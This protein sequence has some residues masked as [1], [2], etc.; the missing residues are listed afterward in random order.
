MPAASAA[1]NACRAKFSQLNFSTISR[2]RFPISNLRSPIAATRAS[3]VANASQDFG[4]KMKPLER[5]SKEFSV[6]SWPL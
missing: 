2:D 5:C 1:R 6:F 4:S 3:A